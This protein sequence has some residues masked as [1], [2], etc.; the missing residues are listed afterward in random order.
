MT[1]FVGPV[2]SD[3][4]NERSSTVEG[5]KIRIPTKSRCCT[6]QASALGS[7]RGPNTKLMHDKPTVLDDWSS[8]RR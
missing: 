2:T 5:G 6:K 7:L 1:K 4:Q 3:Q 8:A